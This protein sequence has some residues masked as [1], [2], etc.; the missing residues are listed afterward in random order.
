MSEESGNLFQVTSISDT[1]EV[2]LNSA[3]ALGT[4]DVFVKY[5]DNKPSPLYHTDEDHNDIV[6]DA[7]ENDTSIQTCLKRRPCNGEGKLRDYPL[8]DEVNTMVE[9]ETTRRWNILFHF[10]S[11]TSLHAL[12]L[13]VNIKRSYY[14]VVFWIAIMFISL[15]LM[16][17]A[18]T[19][20]T[21]QYAEKNTILY[22][23][24]HFNE[25]L[26]FPAIT[27]CNK[28]LYRKSVIGNAEV[29]ISNVILNEFSGYSLF[30]DIF[31]NTSY[32]NYTTH[33]AALYFNNSGH[34][35][36]QILFYCLYAGNRCTTQNFTQ[37]TST[38]GNCHTFNSGENGSTVLYSIE[39]GFTFGL[40]LILNAEQY[41]YFLADSDSVG[42][43][44]FI[45]DQGHFPYYGGVNSFSI[46]PGQ[47]TQ[48]ALRKVDY[49]LQTP[50]GGGQ[51]NNDIT[52]KYFDSYSRLSCIVEC[53]TDV[54]VSTCDCKG[55]GMPGPAPFCQLNDLCMQRTIVERLDQERCDCPI[56]CESTIYQK[57]LS[58]AKFPADHIA[59]LLNNSNIL[60]SYPFPDFIISNDTDGNG[61]EFH[62][63]NDNF[64]ESFLSSNFA[65]VFIYYDELVSTTMEEG[66][67]YTTFQYIADFGGYIGV[68]TGAGF[69]TFFEIVDLCY[70]VIRPID[71]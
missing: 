62:Y 57:T 24:Q 68:F 66:L 11:D 7:Q 40:E 12:P 42:F 59:L 64:T 33:S 63:L 65:K 16:F 17:W 34:Q 56:A 4:A 48:V 51:C 71:N 6:E 50:A 15:G 10:F 67:R 44:M 1:D 49:K 36:E 54:I 20:V 13:I 47:S 18:L 43:N 58:Y 3:K 35:I 31:G 46:S 28:N 37:G 45:H 9:K 61:K 30:A 60:S 55:Q 32:Y 52:L 27:I 53:V 29:N 23:T 22:S 69:L 39:G 2:A 8:H 14:R 25:R 21:M 70:N 26:R 19:A 5:T 38:S 41:E